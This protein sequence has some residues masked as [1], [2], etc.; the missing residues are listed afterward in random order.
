MT[1]LVEV[2]DRSEIGAALGSGATA[3]GI[4]SRNL[5]D[6]S[7]NPDAFEELLP[8]VPK[9]RLAVA[10]S[11]IKTAEDVKRLKALGAHAVLVGESLL[12]QPDLEQA[13]KILVEAGR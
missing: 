9:D 10:E 11:G 13:A 3:V 7:M 1:P 12:R 8:L 2:H 4:N 5:K 6:L